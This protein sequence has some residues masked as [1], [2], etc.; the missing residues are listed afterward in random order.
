MKIVGVCAC[1]TGVAHTYL[2]AGKIKK[3]AEDRGHSCKVE[4]QGALGFEDQLKTRE[5]READV[6]I[7]AL[8]VGCEMEER[9]VGKKILKFNISEVLKDID[10]VMDKV[11]EAVNN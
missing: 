10:K 11:E 1:P 4:K 7:M 2:A 5:I 3:A 9:F 8:M 6:V